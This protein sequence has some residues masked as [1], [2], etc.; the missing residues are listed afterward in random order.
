M[1]GLAKSAGAALVAGL[2]SIGAFSQARCEN[3]EPQ[4][5]STGFEI[6]DYFRLR[7]I[8]E[9]ALSSDGRWLAYV[10]E[11]YSPDATARTRHVYVHSLDQGAKETAPDAL[12]D[13]SSFSWISGSHELAFL[14]VRAGTT[15]VF[16]YDVR[17]AQTR[18]RTDSAHP[19]ESFRFSPRGGALAYL[20]REESVQ[21]ESLYER[22]RGDTS[23]I[24]IDP[25]NTSSHD[26]LNPHWHGMVKRD[27]AALWIASDDL[28]AVRVAVPGEPADEFFWSSDGARLSITYVANDIPESQLGDQYTSVGVYDL[29]A[30]S[31]REIA[32]AAPPHE[33]RPASSFKGGEWI[34]GR[35]ELLIRRVIHADPWVSDSFPDWAVARLT[36]KPPVANDEWLAIEAYPTGLAFMPMRD[37]SVLVENTVRGV[38]LLF[39]LDRDGMRPDRR[40]AALEGGSSMFRFSED[41]GRFAFVHE[42]LVQPPEI[43]VARHGRVPRQ[44]TQLN[45]EV[46]RQIRFRSHEMTWRSTDGNEIRGWLLEPPGV[47]PDAGWPLVT[48]VHG[49]PAFAY[50]NAFA[51]YFAYWPYPIE[52]YAEHGIAVFMPNYRGTHSY[53]RQI[54]TGSNE[55]AIDDI[56]T[57]VR[58]LVAEGVV[59]EHRLGVSGH[60]HGAFVGPLAMARAKNFRAASFA[61]G[62]A[63]SVVAY[64]L[65]S[66][67]ANREIHDAIVGASLYEAPQRYLD[68]SPDLHFAGLS[69][70][71]LFEGGAYTAALYMLGFTKAAS[72]AGMPTE[73]V[74]YPQTAHNIAMP[75]LQREAAERNLDWFRSWL[76]GERK[77]S[78]R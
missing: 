72:R 17:T 9:L 44:L 48:H 34:P 68:E 63:N 39:R 33:G 38:R 51:P 36:R 45:A 13:G 43:Y 28:G 76:L 30:R 27:P 3:V 16:S 71:A 59:D 73:F 78:Q 31:F 49:G 66:E 40:I 50:P 53:G 61:E 15:H 35:A 65:M 52:V 23:G 54:A 6:G 4:A 19:V 75:K 56:V 42:S 37:G 47:R 46:A 70:A 62:V 7:R 8:S 58:K 22:F 26:F 20:T 55:Q 25:R 77:S 11:G 18:R 74:V 24:V 2:L 21:S 10:V 1:S 60:S 5:K 41:F 32:R 12:Q 64:E 57:G 67:D 69:T 29:A 14:A